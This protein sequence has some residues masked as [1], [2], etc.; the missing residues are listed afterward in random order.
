[1]PESIRGKG[2]L[3]TTDKEISEFLLRLCHDLRT[4]LRAI[5]AHTALVL[6]ESGSSRS[7]D[8]E[9]R[10]GFISD[11]IERVDRLT[12]G[13]SRYAIALRI[14]RNLFRPSSMDVLLRAALRKLEPEL[15]ENDAQVG[16][17][18][19]PRV[20]GDPDRLAEL[21]ESL[22]LNAVRHRGSDAPRIHVSAENR[23]GA[24]LFAVRDNG[25]GIE[26]AYLERIFNPFE[27]LPSKGI[28]GP[29]LGLAISRAIVEAHGG[30][31]WAEPA[32][33][34]GAAFFFTIPGSRP[35][36]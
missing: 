31:I 25:P 9:E 4:P 6:R 23:E 22:L 12:D 32:D 30:K 26:A 7:L 1:M 20:L 33:G 10:L 3:V 36:P 34:E 11:G 29:G 24:W 18:P 27:R 15:R 35:T 14:D 2:G 8:M 17:D 21:F 5:Q 13:L 19:L 16:Y 28:A